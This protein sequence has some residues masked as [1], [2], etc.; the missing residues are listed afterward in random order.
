[1]NGVVA[2]L[3]RFS[4]RW[5]YF[6]SLPAFR[7]HPIRTLRRACAWRLLCWRGKPVT[8][9]M[10]QWQ[11]RLRL[12]AE[13]H[14]A[15]VTL[16]YVVREHYEPEVAN[17]GKLVRPGAVFVDAG[18]NCGIYTVA[19]AHFTGPAGRVLAFE[20]GEH[21]LQMLRRNVAL[22]RCGHVRVFPVALAEKAGP[23]R[24]YAHDHGSSSFSLGRAGA[25]DLPSVEVETAT[26]DAILRQEGLSHVD[27]L[28]M[29]VEGAEELV[30]RGAL[31]LFRKCRPAVI[32]EVNP[33]AI[34]SLGLSARGAWDFL[35]GRGYRFYAMGDGGEL[36]PIREPAPG[37]N[38]VALQ[39]DAPPPVA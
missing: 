30:L 5:R 39:A 13:W 1:M 36:T 4:G 12:D 29:D 2:L 8:V 14:G 38:V 28:K 33:E 21:A 27:V 34:A 32:F 15:G 22:N 6:C 18:A 37:S 11:S 25:G 3:Q 20:P 7:H 19:A 10:P 16:F 31:E 35:A 23:A 9:S 24:L 17:L 26:L